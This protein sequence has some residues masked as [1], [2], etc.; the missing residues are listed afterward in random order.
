[1]ALRAP[2]K[3][4]SVTLA[5]LTL[6]SSVKV[7]DAVA[8]CISCAGYSIWN[9]KKTPLSSV[10]YHRNRSTLNIGILGYIGIPYLKEHTPELWH[11][12]L[13]HSVQRR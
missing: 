2:Y 10:Y 4:L 1:M 9:R 3:E 7:I 6:H 5:R 11:I 8:R 13:G 12:L